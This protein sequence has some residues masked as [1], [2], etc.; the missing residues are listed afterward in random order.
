MYS[1]L[2]YVLQIF[3]FFVSN[4][5]IVV[6]TF[7]PNPGSYYAL[8]FL[9]P[10]DFLCVLKV[11]FGGSRSNYALYSSLILQLCRFRK[12]AKTN[13]KWMTKG[14]PKALKSKH[15]GAMGLDFWFWEVLEGP[16]FWT[17][18]G[19]NRS[20]PEIQENAKLAPG[21]PMEDTGLQLRPQALVA[22][23][24]PEGVSKS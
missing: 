20:Q 24:V 22:I 7:G 11:F 19:T 16:R 6:R 9:K 12:N 4:S 10:H 17:N 5:C 13:T 3:V 23:W 1:M 18:F 8:C 15:V 2:F 21:P 14:H